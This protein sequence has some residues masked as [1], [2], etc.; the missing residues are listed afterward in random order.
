MDRYVEKADAKDCK[1][2]G[3]EEEKKAAKEDVEASSTAIAGGIMNTTSTSKLGA[4]DKE[5]LE[6]NKKH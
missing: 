5:I 6:E 1:A 4:Q 3:T 2:K